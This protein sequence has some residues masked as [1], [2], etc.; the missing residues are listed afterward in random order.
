LGWLRAIAK[1]RSGIAWR[2]FERACREPERAQAESWAKQVRLMRQGSWWPSRMPSDRL[3]DF[4]IT[5]YSDYASV[6]ESDHARPVSS[7]T[8]EPILH[9]AESTGT[10]G[11]RKMLP[12]TPSYKRQFQSVNLP[13]VAGLIRRFPGFLDTKILYLT[14]PGPSERTEAGI[15]IGF[16]SGYN[17]L[18]TPKLLA[19]AYALPREVLRD[20]ATYAKWAPIH[21]AVADVGGVLSITPAR[22]RQLAEEIGER[23]AEILAFARANPAL[24]TASRVAT[25]ERAFAEPR[26]RLKALWPRL[27][28]VGSWKTSGCGPQVETVMPYLDDSVAYV[29]VMYSATE[30]WINVPFE[31]GRDGGPVHP[32]GV[33]CEFIEV[34]KEMVPANLLPLWKLEPGKSY[35]IFL[36]NQMGLV[37]YRLFDH[38]SCDGFF[39]RSPWIRFTGKALREFMLGRLRIGEQ[40]LYELLARAKVGIP[41]NEI[42]FSRSRTGDAMVVLLREGREAPPDLAERIDRAL[43]ELNPYYGIDRKVGQVKAP[44]VETLPW[45][46]ALW[47]GALHAQVKPRIFSE[48]W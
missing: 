26:L 46:H 37:R 24:V 9:W 41:E 16:I 27:E 43:I 42:C 3:E 36:T 18:H 45:T 7:L 11:K 1:L 23:K 20:G 38:V 25:L 32:G 48:S 17:Y 10:T 33:I 21:A 6:L 15:G 44:T 30:G 29:D 8:G 28:F 34:G 35:E 22:V 14:A 5:Q 39:H 40:Q 31:T 12:L 13:M 2:A 19:R 4:P 47:A